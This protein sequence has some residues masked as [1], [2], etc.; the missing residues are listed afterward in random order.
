MCTKRLPESVIKLQ[1]IGDVLKVHHHIDVVAKVEGARQVMVEQ[2]SML[3]QQLK[4]GIQGPMM[5]NFGD[6]FMKRSQASVYL[7]TVKD[8]LGTSGAS[9]GEELTAL[10]KALIESE[11]GV[12]VRIHA[13]LKAI[14]A[15]DV[16]V[17]AGA[18]KQYLKE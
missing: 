15:E 18:H 4:M 2:A 1:D 16:V 8:A 3:L 12:M 10:N 9:L 7:E 11:E 17:E 13:F 14:H 6:V 5:V